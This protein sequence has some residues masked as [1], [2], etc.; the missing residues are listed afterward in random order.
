MDDPNI[1][2]STLLNFPSVASDPDTSL[3]EAIRSVAA[4]RD[5]HA[6]VL[7]SVLGGF[8]DTHYFR[9]KGITSYGFSGLELTAE[10]ARGV[11]GLNERIPLAALRDA[12][13]VLLEVVLSIDAQPG[14]GNAHGS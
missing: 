11:H 13:Q 2:F 10:D 3:F 5:P 7:P 14:G 8:T 4:R 1:Q 6:P 12:V 9:E